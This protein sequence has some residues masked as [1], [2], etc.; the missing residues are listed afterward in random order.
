MTPGPDLRAMLAGLGPRVAMVEAGGQEWRGSDLLRAHEACL[1]SAQQAGLA[2]GHRMAVLLPDH[3]GTALAIL[4]LAGHASVMPLNP[5]LTLAELGRLVL[6]GRADAI[7]ARPGDPLAQALAGAAGVPMLTLDPAS[8]RIEGRLPAL[9][10][11]RPPGLVLLTSGSTG[12]PKRVP[13]SPA[14]L[15]HSAQT[16]AATLRLT[17]EDRAGHALPMFHIGALVDLVLSPLIAGGSVAL[18]SARTPDALRDLVLGRGVTWLQLVPTML[19]RCMAE[20]DAATARAI[21]ARLRFIRSVSAD[22]APGRQAEA[23][24]HFGTPLVQMYG[25]TETAGQIA[26]NPVPPGLRKPGS[27]GL[28]ASP[29]VRLLDATGSVVAAGAEGEICLR[30]PSVTEG[31]EATPRDAHFHGSWLRSGDLGRFDED[32]Y[33]FLTG[34]VK[35]MINRGGEKIAPVE[36]ERA[37]LAIPGVA[38]AVAYGVPHPTLGEQVGLSLT[39]RPGAGLDGQTILRSLEGQ[40]APFKRPRGIDIRTELPRLGSGKIDR[41]ALRRTASGEGPAAPLSPL[42]RRVGAIWAEVLRGPVPHPEDDFFDAGGDSLAAT[43]FLLRIE[44]LL[45]LPVPGNLL[46]ESPRFGAFV[47][48]LAALTPASPRQGALDAF[49]LRETAA[50][51]GQRVLAGGLV[52]GTGT[53][54]T[55]APVFFCAQGNGE[56]QSIRAVLNPERPLYLMRSLYLMPGRTAEA[57]NELARRYADE[58]DRIQPEGPVALGGFCAGARVMADVSRILQAQGRRISAFLSIDHAFATPTPYRVLHVWTECPV[59]P[60]PVHYPRPEMG[61]DLLHPAGWQVLRVPGEHTLAMTAAIM[62]PVGAAFE[63]L[64][65]QLPGPMPPPSDAFASRQAMKRAHIEARLPRILRPGQ[66]ALTLRVTNASNAI[67]PSG[68]G[69]AFALVARLLGRGTRIFAPLAGHADLPGPIAPGDTMEIV[70]PITVPRLWAP[71][72]IEVAM[73]DQGIGLFPAE[74]SPRPSRWALVLPV[75]AG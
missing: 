43:A 22:L 42:A 10:D 5:D 27:V 7:L 56:C 15:W 50:W 6:D 49:L 44:A 67:W 17:P 40:L 1:A 19:S 75:K 30:G 51:P 61:L 47:E 68:P 70:M 37:A 24:A 14:N 33:L 2:P 3:P 55:L 16:I 21:G 12:T 57:E 73:I 64:L 41:A 34:R 29:E 45:G 69:G 58:I 65:S 38:E 72:R 32:G 20:Y 23:E 39:L 46:F 28:T 36:V 54:G 66:T 31:Y 25:M 52:L 74:T 13:L 63:G 59:H 4:T 35:E 9:A 26:S 60:A 8:L 48:R 71:V 53:A 11:P 62:A 18:A